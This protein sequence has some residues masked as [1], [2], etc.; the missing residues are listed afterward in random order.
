[1]VKLNKSTE[2]FLYVKIYPLVKIC[3]NFLRQSERNIGYPILRYVRRKLDLPWYLL[4]CCWFYLKMF[5]YI[6]C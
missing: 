2:M 3:F 6:F 4:G 5:L 1:M